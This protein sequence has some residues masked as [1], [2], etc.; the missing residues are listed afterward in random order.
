MSKEPPDIIFE[1]VCE[2]VP[3][4]AII[5]GGTRAVHYARDCIAEK[6]DGRGFFSDHRRG[7]QPIGRASEPSQ[8]DPVDPLD[9]VSQAMTGKSQEEN[10]TT[11]F[12]RWLQNTSHI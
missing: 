4:C 5:E 12:K 6:G 2:E 8:P 11:T 9:L 3:Q 10:P 1:E 7:Q